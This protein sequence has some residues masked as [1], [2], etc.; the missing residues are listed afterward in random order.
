MACHLE[1]SLHLIVSQRCFVTRC[2][3]TFLFAYAKPLQGLL[4]HTTHSYPAWQRSSISKA[5]LQRLFFIHAQ[6]LAK[7]LSKWDLA[8]QGLRCS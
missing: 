1:I 4:G 2:K 8:G 6:V 7:A 5:L 3:F